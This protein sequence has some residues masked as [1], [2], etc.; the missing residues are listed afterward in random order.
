MLEER[1]SS[2]NVSIGDA[3]ENYFDFGVSYEQPRKDS[4]DVIINANN[5]NLDAGDS[6]IKIVN[7]NMEEASAE[8]LKLKKSLLKERLL[9]RNLKILLSLKRILF[10]KKRLLIY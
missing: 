5:V 2:E 1:T 7:H 4:A 6:E 9:I 8:K 3:E 10:L